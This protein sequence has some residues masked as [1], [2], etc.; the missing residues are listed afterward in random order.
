MTIIVILLGIAVLA[1]LSGNRRLF[2]VP[3]FGFIVYGFA[4]DASWYYSVLIVLAGIF[5]FAMA[6]SRGRAG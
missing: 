3:G 6:F 1:V 4:Y 5:L 2:I